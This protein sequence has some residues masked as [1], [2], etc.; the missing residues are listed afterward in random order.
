MHRC[1]VCSSSNMEMV[2]D[3]GVQPLSGIFPSEPEEQLLRGPLTVY[4]CGQC[5]LAQLG[6]SYPPEVLYGDNYGYRSGLNRSMVNH[7]EGVARSLERKI[8]LQTR[9]V[10]LDIG[11]N[12]GTLLRCYS[13][14][15]IQKI[16]IDPTIS[17][18]ADHYSAEDRITRVPELF[19]S[20]IYKSATNQ[21]AKIITSI[22][23]FYDLEDPVA[24]VLDI[25]EI[26]DAEGL[27]VLEQSY[28]P[29]MLRSGAFDTICHEHLEYYRLRDIARIVG[30]AGLRVVDVATNQVNGGS[31]LVTVA[32]LNSAHRTTPEVDWL[33]RQET[34]SIEKLIA[35]WRDFEVRVALQ[36]E[37]FF[38]LLNTLTDAGKRIAALGAS[39]KGNVLLNTCG[40]TPSLV[41]SIGEVNPDKY[42]RF[43]PGSG[44]PIIPENDVISAEPDYLL[45]LPW[46]FR[47]GLLSNLDSFLKRGGK[48]ILPLPD[49]EIVTA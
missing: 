21:K 38:D 20:D 23:M 14:R 32:H 1:R 7:L 44:I 47:E 17:K 2:V 9:D 40:V 13:N 12:D 42:G 29:W 5:G 19:S 3:L 25:A 27:W 24:F 30:M 26:L 18:F 15:G 46:H 33:L 43:A 41:H 34:E 49:V 6:E 11:A 22:A 8:N 39:T 45:L 48:A 10:I 4:V 36:N 31:F 37:S 28:A 35:S 16:G